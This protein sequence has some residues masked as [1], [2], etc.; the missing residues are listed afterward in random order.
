MKLQS[1]KH[2]RVCIFTYS[3]SSQNL[4]FFLT[5]FYKN[6]FNNLPLMASV[7]E[8][9]ST[10]LAHDGGDIGSGGGG[11]GSAG[12]QHGYPGRTIPGPA[13]S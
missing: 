5:L 9:V 10:R 6:F 3:N 7:V 12:V 11:C 13:S 1:V 8:A 4:E 2:K